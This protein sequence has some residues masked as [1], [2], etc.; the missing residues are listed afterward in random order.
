MDAD[1]VAHPRRVEL[2]LA[3]LDADPSLAAVG[4]RVRLFPRREVAGG[5]A[6]YA[7]LAERARDPGT[8]GPRPARRGAARP[9]RLGHPA[10]CARGG[11][12]L[13]RRRLSRG[14]RPVAAPLRR[15]PA[16]LEPPRDPARLARVAHSSHPHRRPLRAGAPH[17]AQGGLARRRA[18]LRSGARWRSGAPARPGGPSPARSRPWASRRS[19][20]SRSIPARSAG[21]CSVRR[22][23][24]TRR[25]S[26]RADCRS[27]S[28]WALRGRASSS[29]PSSGRRGFEED[30]DYRCVA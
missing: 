5:M 16:P 29:A 7:D 30:R 25:P 17:G 15:G 1:D 26:G 28:R 11:R 19:S 6:R 12:R 27:W 10:R 8:G 23:S 13:A 20:S 3:A 18:A 14:L 9:P 22:W 2:Q 24:R 21:P 4:S